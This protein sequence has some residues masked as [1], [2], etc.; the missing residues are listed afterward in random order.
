M[1][2]T[3]CHCNKLLN[4]FPQD[5]HCVQP[6]PDSGCLRRVFHS[7][8]PAHWRPCKVCHLTCASEKIVTLVEHLILTLFTVFHPK[9]LLCFCVSWM[10]TSVSKRAEIS[11]TYGGVGFCSSVPHCKAGTHP[12]RDEMFWF[13][14]DNDFFNSYFLPYLKPSFVQAYWGLQLQK[15]AALRNVTGLNRLL[16]IQVSRVPKRFWNMCRVFSART[17]CS[18]VKE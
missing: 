1:F 4:Y 2:I 5:H 9:A 3:S 14:K 16:K 17:I 8:L 18:H 15:E 10:V 7:S 6:R 13:A 12:V 11:Q